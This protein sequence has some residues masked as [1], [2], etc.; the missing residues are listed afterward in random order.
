[1]RFIP[2]VKPAFNHENP[3][4]W[5]VFRGNELLIRTPGSRTEIPFTDNS[6]LRGLKLRK[7]HYL[8]TLDGFPCYSTGVAEKAQPPAGM[9]FQGIRG[10]FALL[11][12]ELFQLA[13]RALHILL[14]DR[15]SQFC[16]RCGSP[17]KADAVERAKVCEECG[18]RSYPR[19]SPATITAVRRDG[20]I[21]LARANRFPNG[22]YSVIAGFV[23]PGETLEECVER[24][25]MEETGIQV[26][27]ICY[28]GSQPWPFPDSLMVA[29]TADYSGGE[30][31][32][33]ENEIADAG[34]FSADSLPQIP[35]KL[36][37]ARRLIDNFIENNS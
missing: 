14:W 9:T 22:L 23:E 30:I 11:G 33:D 3:G 2:F 27:N 28:F 17:T 13:C 25:I 18:L 16:G 24:E 5:F 31:R 6:G 8:G 10:T 21:L 35:E 4:W 1:M 36:S 20:Q 7:V 34:W 15:N 29:F 12:E 37:I 19:I 32:I 26:K